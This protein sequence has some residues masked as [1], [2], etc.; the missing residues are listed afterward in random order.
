MVGLLFAAFTFVIVIQF[1]KNSNKAALITSISLSI[2]F[3]YGHILNVLSQQFNLSRDQPY[4]IIVLLI[5]IGWISLTIKR[6]E[7]HTESLTLAFNLVA[8]IALIIPFY[9]IFIMEFNASQSISIFE[10]I[11]EEDDLYQFQS[12]QPLPDVYYIILDAYGRDDTLTQKF[13]LDNTPF[14]TSLENYGFYIANCS[15][16]NYENTGLSLSSSLN[17]NYIEALS[18][19]PTFMTGYPKS[20]EKFINNSA[21]RHI[22]Q[23][24]GYKTVAFDTGYKWTNIEDAEYYFTPPSEPFLL[25]RINKFESLFINTTLLSAFLNQ[26]IEFLDGL[27]SDIDPHDIH[28]DRVLYTLD[29][30]IEIP[31]IPGPK[32]VF[33]HITSPHFPFVFSSDGTKNINPNESFAYADQVVYLNSRLKEVIKQILG[34]STTPPIILVQGDHG[35]HTESIIEHMKILSAYNLPNGGEILLYPKVSP[36]NN[37]RIILNYY[38]GATLPLLEDESFVFPPEDEATLI[39]VTD[40]RDNCYK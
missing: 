18:D 20:A 17:L 28:R 9:R 6:T 8:I 4:L 24:M 37:F 11:P 21:I 23:G 26:D 35:P 10:G 7:L 14:L 19:L 15:M 12:N 25:G 29:Q 38:F 31:K 27:E 16:S 32:F 40:N 33:A 34:N 13:L 39:P 5:I 1:I 2:F 36:V 3:T 30:L 22:F